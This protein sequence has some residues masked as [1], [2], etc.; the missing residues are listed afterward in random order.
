MLK[1]GD[2]VYRINIEK[3]S[4]DI[5]TINNIIDYGDSYEF[6]LRSKNPNCKSNGYYK[7][8]SYN[9]FSVEKM[10]EKESLIFDSTSKVIYFFFKKQKELTDELKMYMDLR[11]LAI[12]IY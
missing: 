3:K 11:E 1:I 12:D 8:Y 9:Q 7:Y 10:M 2:T 4:F 6:D 5:L